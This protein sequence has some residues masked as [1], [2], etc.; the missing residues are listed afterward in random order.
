MSF[1]APWS[2][3]L[4]GSKR[5]KVKTEMAMAAMTPSKEEVDNMRTQT[6]RKIM[7]ES[8]GKFN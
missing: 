5:A 1:S 8:N 3:T 4:R 6:P 2:L 7:Q